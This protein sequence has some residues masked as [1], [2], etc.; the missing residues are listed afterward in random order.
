MKKSLEYVKNIFD[1]MSRYKLIFIFIGFVL[2]LDYIF[3]TS[4][5][6][7]SWASLS[8]CFA[9][10]V[11]DIKKTFRKKLLIS[12]PSIIVIALT[13]I[14][15]FYYVFVKDEEGLCDVILSLF[16]SFSYYFVYEFWLKSKIKK[17]QEYE[18]KINK[19]KKQ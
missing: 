6:L 14:F 8:V 13:L 16:I 2:I 7:S 18:D 1:D 9:L 15:C 12:V 5:Y 19:E 3:I 4:L 11:I 10:S 17:I